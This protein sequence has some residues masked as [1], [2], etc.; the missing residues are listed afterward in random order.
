[1]GVHQFTQSDATLAEAISDWK[2]F[3]SDAIILS[4]KDI[5]MGVYN[6]HQ[7]LF[8]S[9]ASS[10]TAQLIVFVYTGN[11]YESVFNH[12]VNGFEI[13]AL[14]EDQSGTKVNIDYLLSHWIWK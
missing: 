5:T 7:I 13:M 6:A 1:V 4:E 14:Y 8:K 2:G 12:P 9:S 11:R 3:N 10:D